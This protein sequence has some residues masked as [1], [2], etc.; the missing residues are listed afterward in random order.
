MIH[1]TIINK[2]GSQEQVSYK[3]DKILLSEILNMQSHQIETPCGGSGVCG[4]CVVYAQGDLSSPSRLEEELGL[5]SLNRRLACTTYAMGQV[6]IKPLESK[7]SFED[8]L[9]VPD[10]LSEHLPEQLP[11]DT[12]DDYTDAKVAQACVPGTR[13]VNIAI[14]VGTTG[15]SAELIDV[16]QKKTIGRASMLNPQARYGHDVLTRI[17]HARDQK[18]GTK[19]LSQAIIEG[20][21][22]LVLK[23]VLDHKEKIKDN[24]KKDF[25]EE[26]IFVDKIYVAGNTTMQHL[27][28]EI[29]P[30]PIAIAPYK[31]VF[32]EAKKKAFTPDVKIKTRGHMTLLP[33]A[34]AYIGADITAGIFGTD[35]HKRSQYQVKEANKNILFIDIGTNGE[36][37]MNSRN[38]LYATSTAAGP[39]LEGMNIACGMRAQSGAVDRFSINDEGLFEY[40]TIGK[41]EATGICGSG[42]IDI[43]AELVDKEIV[44]ENGRFNKSMDLKYKSKFQDKKFYIGEN[45]YLS[46]KDIRQIQLAKGA[47]ATGIE[48]LYK[49]SH[50]AVDDCI[51]IIVAGSFGYHLSEKNI[52]KIGLIPKTFKAP[53]RFVGNSSLLGVKKALVQEDGLEN[54]K[55]IS[56]QIKLVELSR[57]PDFQEVFIRQLKF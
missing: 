44:L 6:I 41:S 14:D 1:A 2:D 4:K 49:A 17:G 42:L 52:R 22:Q 19:E 23:L 7:A 5:I 36:I 46:Q 16:A 53:V 55:E 26:E 27:I 20:L 54:I 35:F 56:E 10:P 31:P 9:Y 29:N 21:N 33:S 28:C 51:E 15:V 8:V 43:V 34:S 40:T 11:E 30:E 57:R 13:M 18:N 48:L 24:V 39:A 47:I 12:C 32:L 38:G 3:A 50:E 37:V 45:I 25:K